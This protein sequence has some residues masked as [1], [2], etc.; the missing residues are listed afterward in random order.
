MVTHGDVGNF[1]STVGKVNMSKKQNQAPFTDK[2][3][4]QLPMHCFQTS[5]R[6]ACTI[7]HPG[8]AAAAET[9]FQHDLQF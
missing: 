6:G 8:K 4:L 5:V 3:K 7:S 1:L 2:Q 9:D